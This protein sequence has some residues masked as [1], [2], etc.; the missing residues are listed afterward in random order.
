[1]LTIHAANSTGA[2]RRILPDSSLKPIFNRTD[3]QKRQMEDEIKYQPQKYQ[4]IDPWKLYGIK[5]KFFQL[6]I[7]KPE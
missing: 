5:E 6:V 7:I 3:G 4:N 1:M 2:S